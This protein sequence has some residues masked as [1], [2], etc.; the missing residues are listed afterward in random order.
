MS[1]NPNA[2]LANQVGGLWTQRAVGVAALLVG[3][4]LAALFVSGVF[5]LASQRSAGVAFAL[6]FL[7]VIG[8]LAAFFVTVGWRMA[9]NRPNRHG[10]LLT[11]GLWFF[12][13]VVFLILALTIASF[14][15]AQRRFTDLDTALGALMF[16][17]LAVLAGQRA[18][19]KRSVAGDMTRDS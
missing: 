18:M 19:K 5:M 11:P 7:A 12:V 17:V 6:I 16:A 3:L 9:L 10:S 15:V 8:A 2:P 13:A 1:N 14:S 4:A